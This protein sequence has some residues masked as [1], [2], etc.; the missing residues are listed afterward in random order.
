MNSNITNTKTKE[1][2]RLALSHIISEA[3]KFDS[4]LSSDLR[5][6]NNLFINKIR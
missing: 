3:Q 6:N 4:S 5:N 1:N 2:K